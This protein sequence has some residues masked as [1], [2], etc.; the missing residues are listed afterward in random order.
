MRSRGTDRPTDRPT[1][2]A[3]GVPALRKRDVP[4]Y[5]I[6]SAPDAYYFFSGSAKYDISIS[7]ALL[8]IAV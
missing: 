6:T 1:A 8:F 5:L 3:R 4:G 2:T 7:H